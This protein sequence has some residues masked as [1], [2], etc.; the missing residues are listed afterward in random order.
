MERRLA[1]ILLTDMVEYSRLMGLDEEGTIWRQKMHRDEIFDPTI[2]RHGGRIVKTTGDGLLVEFP[3]VVDAVKCAVEVQKEMAE[4]ETDVPQDR[5]IQY[6]IGI[7]LGDIVIDGDDSLGDGVN[8]A[9]RLEGL[10]SPGGVCISGAVYD[11]L[12]GKLDV[13]FEDAG[14]QTVKNVPRPVRVWHWPTDQAARSP[15]EVNEPPALPD[16]PS[17]AVLPFANMSGDP[18]QEYFADGMTEDIITGLSRFRSLFVIA[19]NSTFS[20]KGK[21]PDVREVANDL[22]VRYVLEGSVRR[23]GNRI[24]ITGQL[25]DAETGNHLWVERYDRDLEDIFAVQ[26]E[27]TATIVAA[28]A[29]EVGNIERERAQRKPPGSLDAWDLYQ[30]GLAAAHLSTEAGI[31]SAAELFDRVNEADPT[32]APAFAMAANVRT[33]IVKHFMPDDRAELLEQAQKKAFIAVQLDPRDPMGL[34]HDGQVDSMFGRHDAAISKGEEAVALNPNDARSHSVLSEFLCCA[35]RAEDAIPHMDSAIRLSPRDIYLAGMLT[36]RGFQLFDLE[37][38]E[39]ALENVRR[40]LLR[41]NPRTMTFALMTVVLTKLGRREE[42][43]VALDDLLAHAPNMTCAKFRENQFG[44]PD[45]MARFADALR[46]A[47]LPE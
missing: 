6:R 28:I 16:K 17:I 32:F 36:S 44:A 5:R 46:E 14:E 13:V 4:R 24:R 43:R 20:Y 39:E 37:R 25:I 9:A 23:G 11:Q 31:S 7:N 47:G 45:A 8:V 27:V 26:D 40:A 33:R 18:E 42:A 22:G 12:A 30:R 2:S 38:H 1:A 35:G 29:P 3:S 34:L 19:R 15:S 21:S 41:T 10:A